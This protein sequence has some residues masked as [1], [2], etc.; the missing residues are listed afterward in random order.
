MNSLPTFRRN[1]LLLE[2]LLVGVLLV[3][4]HYAASR[5]GLYYA[6]AAT[7]IVTHFLG[8]VW[9]SLGAILFFFTAGVVRLPWRDARVVAVVSLV[10]TLAVGLGW[11][12]YELMVGLADP[13]QDRVDTL[14]D[15]AFDLAGGLAAFWYFR[16]AVSAD[17][18]HAG[19]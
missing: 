12:V 8:G 5:L 1:P 10:A 11:E 7:D 18:T 15:L 6:V 9:V 4:A 17:E 14:A 3:L 19:L 13:V 2:F 16:A